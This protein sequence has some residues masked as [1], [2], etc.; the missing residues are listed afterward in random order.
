MIILMFTQVICAKCSNYK[1]PLPFEKVKPSTVCKYCHDLLEFRKNQPPPP[2]TDAP[3][4]NNKS[5][6]VSKNPLEVILHN[7]SSFISLSLYFILA[8]SFPF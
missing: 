2:V 6:P 8:P 4:S 7:S 3:D 5:G 1:F